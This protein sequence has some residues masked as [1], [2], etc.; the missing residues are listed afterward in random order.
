MVKKV[1]FDDEITLFWDIDW[2]SDY[3]VEYQIFLN[4]KLIA[5]TDKTHF[6][7]KNLLENQA[8]TVRIERLSKENTPELFF[9][10][11]IMT[12]KKKSRIDVTKSPYFA[13]GDGISKNTEK[14]QKALDDC[15]DCSCVYFPKGTYLVGALNVKSDTEIYLDCGAILQGT[16]EVSDYAPKCLSR[17]E[18]IELECYRALLNIGKMDNRGGC[19]CKN[20]VIRGGGTVSGGGKPL[21][22][23]IIDSE[24]ERLKEFLEKN[25]E[26]VS[27]CECELTIPGR[28]RSKLVSVCNAEN[29]IF[30]NVTFQYGSTWNVHMVYSK[31][32]VTYNCNIVSH[33]VWNGD[34][35]DPDSSEDCT[36]FACN[37]DTGDDG[38]AIKSGKNPEGNII[39]RPTKNVRIF[40]CHGK[41]GI[42]IGS[43]LSGGIENVYIWDCDMSTGNRGFR[44]KTTKKRGGYVKNVRM[45]DCYFSG[46]RV[47]SS[48]DCNDDG[49]SSNQLTQIQDIQ[50]ANVICNS[51][52][53]KFP[54]ENG[55]YE[56]PGFVLEG[57]DEK[58]YHI[59]NVKIKG[60]TIKNQDK[61]GI[62]P[63]Q[64]KN[65]S[66]VDIKDLSFEE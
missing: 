59:K 60:L 10:E 42:A 34:G 36:L 13:L 66:N 32:V 51:V 29:V 4:E 7:F 12:K 3:K 31:N 57:F 8:Y 23:A 54:T 17:F 14:I 50:I 63:M 48:Y 18:G 6:E 20:V 21:A 9:T 56:Y 16:A 37:L 65:V 15:D 43:E 24:K 39:N 64:I 27:S 2:S 22:C 62:M 45:K 49:E 53:A 38:V 55:F 41:D 30:S 25:K 35:W 52:V 46:I 40:D 26:Y 1:V 5:K 47:F 11:E 28:A 58:E 33:D 44:I 19:D 61:C